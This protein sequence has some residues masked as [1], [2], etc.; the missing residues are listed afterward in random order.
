MPRAAAVGAFEEVYALAQAGRAEIV[1]V[2]MVE[3]T[4]PVT[5]QTYPYAAEISFVQPYVDENGQEAWLEDRMYLVES[6]GEWRWFFGSSREFVE[7]AIAEYGGAGPTAPLTE[8]DLHPERR[9]RPR[10]LL[11]RRVRAT[12]TIRTTRRASS[13]SRSATRR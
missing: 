10:R 12:P 13:W 9:R 11:P 7:Q 1:G 2:D 4:W 3:W 5:G 8:G 6:E